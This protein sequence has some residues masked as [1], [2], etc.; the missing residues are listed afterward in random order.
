MT[1]TATV[2]HSKNEFVAVL[3]DGRR[4]RQSE[5]HDL[6]EALFCAGI[7]ASRVDYEWHTGQRMITAGQKAAIKAEIRR[8]GHV[9]G[10]HDAAA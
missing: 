8:L 5:W 2:S 4:I 9:V 3:S 7:S 10:L 6:A 1:T